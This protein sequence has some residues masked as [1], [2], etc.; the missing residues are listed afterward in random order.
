MK[1]LNQVANII[2]KNWRGYYTRKM[3]REYFEQ[4]YIDS[5]NFHEQNMVGL[6]KSQ[7]YLYQQTSQN[8]VILEDEREDYSESN[9]HPSKL[10][11]VEFIYLD[12][13]SEQVK[14]TRG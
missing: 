14:N 1:I 2:Q 6:N 3:L 10:K 11:R 8:Q 4:L 9:T 7:Q 13:Q 12:P 5:Q